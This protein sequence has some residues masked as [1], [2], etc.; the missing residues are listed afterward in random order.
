MSSAAIA[1]RISGN[2]RNVLSRTVS[3][4]AMASLATSAAFAAEAS[5]ETQG[6]DALAVQGADQLVGAGEEQSSNTIIVT[7]RK[8]SEALQDVPLAVS[9]VA[10]DQLNRLDI[11]NAEELTALAPN[12]YT[13]K[14][15]VSFTA[16]Q[17]YMRGVGRSNHNWNAENAVAVFV[18]D[19]YLQ[20]L[21]SAFLEGGDFERVEVLRG[22]Q[23]TLYGRNATTGA[24]KFVPRRPSLDETEGFVDAKYGRRNRFNLTGG[25]SVPLVEGKLGLRASGY[26]SRTDGYITRV[27]EANQVIDDEFAR[28][29][30]FGGRLALLLQATDNLEFELSADYTEY[31]DGTNLVTPIAPADPTDLTQLLSKRGTVRFEPVFGVNRVATQPLTGNGGATFESWGVT[32]KASLET[33][34]GT[35]KSITGYRTYDEFFLAQL[36]GRGVPSTI[37]GLELFSTV[38]STNDY[39]QFS[40][41][42]QFT[43]SLFDDR[44]QFVA[45]GFYFE[46]DWQQLQYGSI[47]GVPAAFSPVVFPGASRSF[48]GTWNDTDQ[49]TVSYALYFDASFE[50]FDNFSLIAGV[51]QSWDEKDVVYDARFE[52]NIL[53]Y[54]GFPVRPSRDYQEFTPR[55]GFDWDITPD[56]LIYATYAKGYKAGNLEGDR[57]SDPVPASTFLD[58]ETVENYEAG[59]KSELFDGRLT[60]NLSAFTSKYINKADLVSPQ[61]VAIADVDIDGLEIEITAQPADGFN[62]FVN[63]GF[64]DAKYRRADAS[65]PIFV[66]DPTGFAPGLG[67]EPTVAPNYSIT[68]GANY[69]H[70][71]ENGSQAFL[72][73]NVQAVDDHFNGL[74][75]QNYDS[76]RVESYEVVDM[77]LQYR[78]GQPG[79]TFSLGINNLFDT[80]YY[81]TGFFGAVPEVAGR[82]YAD[83]RNAYVGARYEF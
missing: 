76:E 69:T 42:L 51:R 39:E 68:A 21:A 58:A 36:G 28:Q 53:R 43:G 54:P 41:E 56:I 17:F 16:P 25:V 77:I 13:S 82:Y 14:T 26:Y 10:G 3:T 6:L 80:T 71:F 11:Q 8:R 33:P 52:D 29:R 20:S 44:F 79:V 45:G 64:L 37:F 34:V 30:H 5:A 57:A 15:T 31:D 40:Q 38:N 81:T 23:G 66:P 46:N 72:G 48:G 50:I 74:G 83:G 49:N 47:I 62:L 35:L 61:T 63:A 9:A 19:I 65:H 1:C 67:A 7:A 75:V 18:D 24:I 12:L 78:L 22:P 4:L 2:K 55:F 32:F 60:F 59:I 70:R 73:V 27:N